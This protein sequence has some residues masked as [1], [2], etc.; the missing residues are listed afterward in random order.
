VDGDGSVNVRYIGLRG[1]SEA[2]LCYVTLVLAI[3]AEGPGIFAL[4]HRPQFLNPGILLFDC[5]WIL[6]LEVHHVAISTADT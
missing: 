6:G 3:E 4:H 2:D 5:R 1:I